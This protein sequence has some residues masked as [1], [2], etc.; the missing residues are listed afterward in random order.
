MLNETGEYFFKEF[1]D[2]THL[3]RYEAGPDDDP[4]REIKPV[5]ERASNPSPP[6]LIEQISAGSLPLGAL[7]IG[8]LKS[9]AVAMDTSAAHTLAN[10]PTEVT[11]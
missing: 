8:A 4:L 3:R 7:E 5:L 11:E 1:P 9:M 2:S 6:M 10:V